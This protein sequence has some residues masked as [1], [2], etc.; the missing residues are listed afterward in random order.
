[1]ADEC[2][3]RVI[4]AFDST[5]SCAVTNVNAQ[6]KF[7]L[8]ILEPCAEFHGIKLADDGG[9]MLYTRETLITRIILAI[10]ALLPT[11][12][13]ECHFQY[14]IDLKP[15]VAP[16]YHCHM[17][18]QGSHS[19][20]KIEL[21]HEKMTTH[22]NDSLTGTIW[23]CHDC[24]E[25]SKPIKPRKSKSQYVVT[26]GTADTRSQDNHNH[27]DVLNKD[28]PLNNRDST[29]KVLCE[30]FKV[31]KCP[32]GISGKKLIDDKRCSY[33]HPKVCMK[34]CRQ[35]SQGKQGCKRGS[36][37]KFY[38]PVL[39]KY[40]VKKRLCTNEQCT[41]VHLRGTAR[42]LP[43]KQPTKN[44]SQRTSGEQQKN[45]KKAKKSN[46]ENANSF[47]EL[48]KLV[49]SMSYKFQQEIASMKL[50]ISYPQLFP[51]LSVSNTP[52]NQAPWNNT[53]LQ[54]QQNPKMPTVPPGF[55]PQLSC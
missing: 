22:I 26:V 15:S 52:W 29:D 31:G 20:E 43:V 30:G 6:S 49:E 27:T 34:F 24:L 18:F 14:T 16:L 8:D 2:S 54:N 10:K 39:C 41:Y 47:L 53:V 35:G 32:H 46:E 7:N 55:T 48:K 23:L 12:C 5:A 3:K 33:H 28:T 19:C 42:K 44:S 21:F 1:M 36:N 40:S 4:T 17:C 50:L 38:H 13:S 25:S 45:S 9:N 37:C 51:A 11:T